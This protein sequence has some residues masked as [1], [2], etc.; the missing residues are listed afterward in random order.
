MFKELAIALMLVASTDSVEASDYSHKSFDSAQKLVSKQIK[1]HRGK[2]MKSIQAGASLAK[3]TA[4]KRTEERHLGKLGNGVSYMM[5][6][7]YNDP[8]C[9]IYSNA[10]ATYQYAQAL[11][12]NGPLC[13]PNDQGSGSTKIVGCEQKWGEFE[14]RHYH[15]SDCSGT[16]FY[17]SYVPQST[18]CDWSSDSLS[19]IQHSC[20]RR[21]PFKDKP[22]VLISQFADPTSCMDNDASN[23]LHVPVDSC[24]HNLK[25]NSCEKN[26]AD[27]NAYESDLCTGIEHHWVE[28]FYPNSY[29]QCHGLNDD[30]DDYD[31]D[32][33]DEFPFESRK[34]S[35]NHLY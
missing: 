13:T 33:D 35:N 25:I 19:Y 17:T 12:V 5:L 6:N 10:N 29:D 24:F 7:F 32:G 16:H 15:T 22:G 23:F 4:E 8:D 28:K 11:S 31:D 9:G 21:W 30:D 34:C 18:T 3:N 27:V 26:V 20:A 1:N 2:L 14:V